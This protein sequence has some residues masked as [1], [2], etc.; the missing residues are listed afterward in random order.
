MAYLIYLLVLVVIPAVLSF[1]EIILLEARHQSKFSFRDLSFISASV[2]LV[3][4]SILTFNDVLEGYAESLTVI[5]AIISLFIAMVLI[6]LSRKSINIKFVI[7]GI[8]NA[9]ISI[10][11][12]YI[13]GLGLL[14]TSL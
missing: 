4:F 5:L 11:A 1:F 7:L 14:F 2:I 9:F 13:L 3:L 10:V 8:I 6:F 12:F